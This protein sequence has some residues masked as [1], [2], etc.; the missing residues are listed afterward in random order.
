[1]TGGYSKFPKSEWKMEKAQGTIVS[2]KYLMTVKSRNVKY[3]M[4]IAIIC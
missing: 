1:V 3:C 4:T 2:S